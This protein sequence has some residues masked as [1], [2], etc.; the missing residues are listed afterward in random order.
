MYQIMTKERAE[1]YRA[2]FAKDTAKCCG[3][4][5]QHF[6]TPEEWERHL[7]EVRTLQQTGETPF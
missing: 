2:K 3:E 4:A 5:F 1:A 7:D 6:D